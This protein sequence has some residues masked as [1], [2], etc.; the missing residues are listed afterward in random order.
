MIIW[1]WEKYFFVCLFFQHQVKLANI[2]SDDYDF[3]YIVVDSHYLESFLE[4]ARVTK[5]NKKGQKLPKKLPNETANQC[6]QLE[7]P[8]GSK[9]RCIFNVRSH[10]FCFFYEIGKYKIYALYVFRNTTIGLFFK[11]LKWNKVALQC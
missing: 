10:T 7:N 5:N 9:E 8:D 3:W 6:T 2:I 11:V 1:S 4:F